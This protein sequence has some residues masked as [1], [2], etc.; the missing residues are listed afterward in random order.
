MAPTSRR[1]GEV[2]ALIVEL[3]RVAA[4]RG[5]CVTFVQ[6]DLGDDA[7]IALYSKLG[8]RE[9]VVHFDIAPLS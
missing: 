5:A 3:K 2:T 6:A 7:A 9:D 8:I 1:H 4:A